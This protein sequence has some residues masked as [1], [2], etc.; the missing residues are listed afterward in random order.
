MRELR[1]PLRRYGN[2]RWASKPR[3]EKGHSGW[4]GWTRKLLWSWWLW[5]L[6]AVALQGA[7]H[8]N[9]AISCS[10]VALVL[11]LVQLARTH[12]PLRAGPNL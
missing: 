10:A 11:Y 2:V 12:S 1:A 8:E 4:L 3:Q 6:F 9:A 5:I 7:D